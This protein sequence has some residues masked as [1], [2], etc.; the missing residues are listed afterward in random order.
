ME[1]KMKR[2]IL[3]CQ[4]LLLWGCVSGSYVIKDQNLSLGD[5]KKSVTSVIGEP[6]RISENQRT[7]H[8]QYFSRKPN[9]KFDPDKSPERAY[10]K[11][12]V[13]GDR[14][15]YDVELEVVV[16]ERQGNHY[17]ETGNDMVEARKIGMDLKGKLNQS[18]EDRNVIDDFRAF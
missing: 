4:T 2:F 17:V 1:T 10:A 15:P 11:V 6:R 5:I 18:R 16:E 14:R 7:Y 9:A 12:I 13:L 8:S 3:I